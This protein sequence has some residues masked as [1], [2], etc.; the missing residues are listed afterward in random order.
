[1]GKLRYG[2]NEHLH[3]VYQPKWSCHQEYNYTAD[4]DKGDEDFDEDELFDRLDNEY[5]DPG[6][7]EFLSGHK[8]DVAMELFRACFGKEFDPVEIVKEV[9][10]KRKTKSKKESYDDDSD[11]EDDDDRKEPETPE[12]FRARVESHMEEW[13]ANNAEAQKG[14]DLPPIHVVDDGSD[15]DMMELVDDPVWAKR[16]LEKGLPDQYWEHFVKG[17]KAWEKKYLPGIP[18]GGRHRVYLHTPE[19]PFERVPAWAS[20]VLPGKH[21]FRI[22]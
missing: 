12:E 8:D 19:G 3:I 18:H 11:D 1:M 10:R 2:F 16:V 4:Y 5:W 20:Y 15:P 14:K 22:Q 17:R 21:G 6:E 9:T 13:L 7:D